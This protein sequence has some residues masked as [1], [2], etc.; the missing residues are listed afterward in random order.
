MERFPYPYFIVLGT[1]HTGSLLT[2][3][4]QQPAALGAS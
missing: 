4:L 3:K 1:E 2:N